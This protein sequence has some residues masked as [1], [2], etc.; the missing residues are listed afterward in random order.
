MAHLLISEVARQT[1][2]RAS[3]IRYYE[4]IGILPPPQR[5]SGQRRYDSTVLYR[6]AIIQRARMM[7]FSLPEIRQLFLGFCGVVKASQR[8]KKLS[9]KKLAS[10]EL[11]AKQIKEMQRLIR[12]MIEQC[13]CSTLE[14]CGKGIFHTAA[15]KNAGTLGKRAFAPKRINSAQR[16]SERC[17]C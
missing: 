14:Q 15:S 10:L 6:L 9:Q 12:D 4:Q 13:Q 7:G 2:L 17:S 8:W 11:L 1:G 3:A 16:S 5:S